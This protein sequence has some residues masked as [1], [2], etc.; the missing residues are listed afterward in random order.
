MIRVVRP[1][2]CPPAIQ[3][4]RT[5]SLSL[6]DSLCCCQRSAALGAI[7]HSSCT[8]LTR[9]ASPRLEC[10]VTQVSVK[11]AGPGTADQDLLAGEGDENT[12]LLQE[13]VLPDG[14][15]TPA[16][17]DGRMTPLA[18]TATPLPFDA[19]STPL[20]WE[21]PASAAGAAAG[22]A[23]NGNGSGNGSVTPRASP[24]DGR[25]GGGRAP[26]PPMFID[27]RATPAPGLLSGRA[28]PVPADASGKVP[29]LALRV[30]PA[31]GLGQTVAAVA[32]A[33]EVVVGGVEGEEVKRTLM[34]PLIRVQE[35]QVRAPKSPLQQITF[36]IKQ[37]ASSCTAHRHVSLRCLTHVSVSVRPPRPVP[38]SAVEARGRWH[39][40]CVRR[41]RRREA[42]QAAA[43]VPARLRRRRRSRR[44]RP[45]PAIQ[46][47]GG[48]QP[49]K[50]RERG[51]GSG[52]GRLQREGPRQGAACA[53]EQA[54]PRDQAAGIPRRESTRPRACP[55]ACACFRISAAAG[56]ARGSWRGWWRVAAERE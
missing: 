31:A 56:A 18:R 1:I 9:F 42:P 6:S 28:T 38:F 55:R 45:H 26:A 14:R 34:R 29:L 50:K 52:G 48:R 46:R 15:R 8:V 16:P 37:A 4:R 51:A 49:R 7:S 43:V 44:R 40:G 24:P 39:P 2:V 41:L 32:A 25:L 23:G 30:E 10:D 11:L 35:I 22:G 5:R 27:G 3:A 33:M 19:R 21:R 53:A 47:R 13:L 12:P 20:P 17:F 36:P 54:A